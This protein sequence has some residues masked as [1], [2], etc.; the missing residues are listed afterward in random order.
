[1]IKDHQRYNLFFEFIKTFGSVGFKGI[2]RQD[3]LILAL[4]E[5]MKINNQFFLI[6]DHDQHEDR[7]Y[8]SREA[9]KCSV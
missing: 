6:F 7:V 9:F 3:P 5:M 2:D 1:M 4:E 8:Q